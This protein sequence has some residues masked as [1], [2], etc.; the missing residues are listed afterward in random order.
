[1][2]FENP[3]TDY[4]SGDILN[5]EG[6]I[7]KNF[8]RWGVGVSAYAMIQTTGDSGPGAQLGSFK[9]RVNGIGP[10]VTYTLGDP[11]NP[12]TFI[13][14]YYQEFDAKNTFEGQSFDIAVTAK[15]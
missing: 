9:S 4:E 8:G 15:F 7:T 13:G 10:I 1:M 2:N 6:N 14:K 11:K 12:L 3:A 5:L